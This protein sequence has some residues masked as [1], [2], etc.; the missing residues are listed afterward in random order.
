MSRQVRLGPFVLR[1]TIGLGAMGTVYHAHHAESRAPV[2]IKVVRPDAAAA[3][4]ALENLAAE[5]RAV[6]ALDHPHIVQ[7]FDVGLVS[8]EEAAVAPDRLAGGTP[9]FAM[10]LA[11]HGTLQR[12][13]RGLDGG[14][15]VAVL[16]QLLEALAH[17]HARGILHLDLKPANVL[18]TAR[19]DGPVLSDF[20][21]G[22]VGDPDPSGDFVRGTPH[23]MAPEQ[24]RGR[25][26]ELG[27]WTDLY[28]FGAIAWLG[29]TGRTPMPEGD[30]SA[31]LSAQLRVEPGA[32]E[33]VLDLPPGFERWVRQLLDKDPDRRPRFAADVRRSLLALS[34]APAPAGVPAEWRTTE[35]EAAA[36]PSDATG[37]GLA[38]RREPP[39]V[40]RTRERTVLWDALRA[41]AD[42][43]PRAVVVRGP[44][45]TGK[46]R[47]ARWLGIRA[48]ELGAASALHAQGTALA[49][50]DPTPAHRGHGVLHD[51]LRRAFPVDLRD[52][53]AEAGLTTRLQERGLDARAASAAA[54]WLAH[55]RVRPGWTGDPPFEVVCDALRAAASERPAVVWLDDVHLAPEGVRFVRHL[56]SAGVPV[57]AVFVLTVDDET[58]PEPVE[59]DLAALAWLPGAASLSLGPLSEQARHSLARRLLPLDPVLAREVADRSGGSPGFTVEL[60]QDLASRGALAPSQRGLTLQPGVALAAP[61]GLVEA[62][63]SHLEPLI[64]AHPEWE[65]PLR[66]AAALGPRVEERAWRAVCRRAG[67][68]LPTALPGAL[69]D[70]H[71]WRRDGEAWQFLLPAMV[72]SL[73]EGLR[74]PSIH[75]ACAEVLSEGPDQVQAGHAWQ[76]AGVPERALDAWLRAAEGQQGAALLPILTRLRGVAPS[77]LDAADPRVMRIAALAAECALALGWLRE[78]RDAAER[79][80]ERAASLADLQRSRML[81]AAVAVEDQSGDALSALLEALGSEPLDDA[82]PWRSTWRMAWAHRHRGDVEAARR[83][84]ERAAPSPA[85]RLERL[86]CDL[87]SGAPPDDLLA[88]AREAGASSERAMRA[89]ATHLEGVLHYLAGRPDE[90]ATAFRAARRRWRT[91]GSEPDER[92][93]RLGL[94]LAFG[95]SQPDEALRLLEHERLRPATPRVG[96]AT[97]VTELLLRLPRP[98]DLRFV[99]VC[100]QVERSVARAGMLD[101]D[102]RVLLQH[103]AAGGGRRERTEALMGVVARAREAVTAPGS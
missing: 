18:F 100:G 43:E 23:F 3:P 47:L 42:G 79:M 75:R 81:L 89:A 103:A 67:I 15:L 40:G 34:G 5:I 35:E 31:I 99:A 71:L 56:L 87:A 21:M 14:E 16:L 54:A 68:P 64:G 95:A 37:P 6:A 86:R 41:A 49:A 33:P 55:G 36:E 57:A 84:V 102:L 13:L 46:S 22:V 24:V 70:A 88:A 93:A 91:L 72:E 28:A 29:A 59:A 27:P 83:W 17:A 82:D 97:D 90:S 4:L 85:Q 96:V 69:V 73:A 92:A 20:G 48:H 51:A 45:G 38:A 2:A 9:W 78:A 12:R 32:F 61:L 53:D 60:L 52:W 63:T 98:V 76:R 66:V 8:A 50:I 44:R 62:S 10:E 58:T 101:L 25:W 74:D 94:L 77:L 39:L 65:L 19:T 30:P 7:I 11:E 80:R 1:D 26:E